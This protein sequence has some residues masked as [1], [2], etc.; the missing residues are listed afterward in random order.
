MEER[1][2]LHRDKPLTVWQLDNETTFAAG[3]ATPDYCFAC[4]A[5]CGLSCTGAL[6]SR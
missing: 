5:G 3:I 2:I 1:P 4:T 6:T